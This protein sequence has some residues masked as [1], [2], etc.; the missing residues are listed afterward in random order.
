[1]IIYNYYAKLIMLS[2]YTCKLYYRHFYLTKLELKCKLIQVAIK[3]FRLL[4][5]L[6]NNF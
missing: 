5:L 4:S 1:M 6:I 3:N 2:L